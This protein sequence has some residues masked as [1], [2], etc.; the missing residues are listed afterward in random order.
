VSE[1]DGT[2][3]TRRR[4][5]LMLAGLWL[6]AAGAGAYEIVPAS[7]APLMR[8]AMGISPTAASGVVSVMFAVAVLG[9]VP[10]GVAVDRV[11]T[12]LVMAGATALLLGAG[13]WGWHAASAGD[14]WTLMASRAFGAIAF[15]TIWNAG[16]ATVGR[17]FESEVRATAIAAFTASGPAGFGL[18]Q[19]TG[20]LVAASMGWEWVF[21]IYG[22]IALLGIAIYLPASAGGSLKADDE[23]VPGLAEFG[24]VLTDRRIWHVSTLAFLAYALYLFVNSWMPTYL[25]QS[26][27]VSLAASGAL[28]GLFALVGVISRVS[29]GAISDRLFG[30]RRRP[31]V[32][33]SFV[34]AT[35]LVVALGTVTLVPVLV[36]ALLGA[37]FFIQFTLGLSLAYARELVAENVAATAIAVATGVSLAGAFVSPI[38]AAAIYERTG[39]FGATFVYAVALAV[40][41]IVL[42]W[43]APEADA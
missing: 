43:S 27:G 10:I 38:A 14:Y 2:G 3:L 22:A 18:G 31:V 41:G 39:S 9:S 12:R 26:V 32:L 40:V 33:L 8:E 4:S 1:T 42:S 20:P 16:A 36:V 13:L 23:P 7:V 29:G 15:V 11:D 17:A 30:T 35:P 5:W 37:G 34:A 24:R 6:V 19:L 28:T 25:V 21:A